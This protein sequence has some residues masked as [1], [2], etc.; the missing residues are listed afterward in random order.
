M[1]ITTHTQ[2]WLADLNQIIAEIDTH[3]IPW[4]SKKN[5]KRKRARKP[6]WEE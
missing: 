1:L 2:A 4:S 3:G 6:L 5:S